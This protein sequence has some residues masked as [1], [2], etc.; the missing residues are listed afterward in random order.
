[1]FNMLSNLGSISRILVESQS[2]ISPWNLLEVA[3]YYAVE[4]NKVIWYKSL[5][6]NSNKWCIIYPISMI[7]FPSPQF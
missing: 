2:N 1:M 4:A 7:C 6:N 3:K 5:K